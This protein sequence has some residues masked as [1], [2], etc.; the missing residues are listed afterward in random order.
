MRVRIQGLAQYGICKAE[1][2][3][4][5][6]VQDQKIKGPVQTRSNGMNRTPDGSGEWWV[7]ILEITVHS[8]HRLRKPDP[9]KNVILRRMRIC[10][11]EKGLNYKILIAA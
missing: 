4:G 10:G 2:D 5:E 3:N 7:K 11:F 9:A 8:R 6:S 1:S